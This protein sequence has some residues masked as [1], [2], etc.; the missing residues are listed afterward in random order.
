MNWSY[1]IERTLLSERGSKALV[2]K[3]QGFAHHYCSDA[4]KQRGM[5]GR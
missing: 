2:P 4:A 3:P 5:G 1:R